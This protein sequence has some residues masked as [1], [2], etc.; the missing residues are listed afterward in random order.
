[1]LD[2]G[3]GGIPVDSIKEML[4]NMDKSE[5]ERLREIFN[6]IDYDKQGDIN[7]NKLKI[8]IND[9]TGEVISD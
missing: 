6:Y 8:M 9:L 7:R 1:M 4:L 5:N 3:K 2:L